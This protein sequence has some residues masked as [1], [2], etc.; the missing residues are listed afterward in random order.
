MI[1]KT[2]FTAFNQLWS[3]YKEH[4]TI[5]PD[6]TAAWNSIVQRSRVIVESSGA[7]ADPEFIFDFAAA[8]ME[9]LDRLSRKN[10]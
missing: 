8:V 3:L 1:D 10:N 9:S 6:D 5:A 4:Q 2:T 7:A